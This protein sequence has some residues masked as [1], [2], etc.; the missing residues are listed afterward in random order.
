[1]ADS[2]DAPSSR[3]LRLNIRARISE[4][5]TRILALENS[6]A[7]ARREREH[8]QSQLDYT[9]PVLTL[10]AEITSHIF[11]HF[12]PNYPMPPPYAGL[13]SPATLGQVCCKWR[14]VALGTPRLWRALEIEVHL[15]FEQ[16]FTVGLNILAAWLARSK[17]C[18]LS[19]SVQTESHGSY[20]KNGSS[21]LRRLRDTIS[22]HSGRLEYLTLVIDFRD[23]R[24]DGMHDPFP[25]LRE[26]VS[27]RRVATI[28]QHAVS[29][30][31]FRCSLSAGRD[32]I[33]FP[34]QIP[35]LMHFKSL[36]LDHEVANIPGTQKLLLDALTTPS[37]RHL[38]VSED[39]LDSDPFA[40]ITSAL[41]RSKCSL[42]SLHVTRSQHDEADYRAAFPSIK[43]IKVL[44]RG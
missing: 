13:L 44:K 35:P 32:D 5:D 37:I 8:L 33:E 21:R 22:A 31:E 11:I 2:E 4:L 14:G 42:H 17:N 41:S 27:R 15:D 25:L 38:R 40:T 7:A 29:L 6:L 36:T 39:E 1:M 43:V 18:S 19:L 34:D 30:V 3:S 12:L 9:Y 24:W 28:L 20:N 26:R 23:L 16:L 10:P